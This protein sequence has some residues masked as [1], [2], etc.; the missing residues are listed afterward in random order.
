MK[1]IFLPFRYFLILVAILH[2]TA[3]S[4]QQY[5]DEKP[6]VP[7]QG[8]W[9]KTDDA[10]R[11]IRPVDPFIQSCV[12]QVSADSI[13][14][15][16]QHL[17][18]FGTRFMLVE[19]R[20]EV[21]TW[22]L[23]RFLSFGYTDV[24]LDSFYNILNWNN[25]YIDSTWQYN[26]VCTMQGSSAPDEEYIVGGHY[27]SFCAPD[28]FVAAPGANDNA[29]AVAATF[30]IAR[31][32]K[33]M[34]Y[35]PEATLKFILFGAEELGLWGSRYDAQ[36]ARETG[37]DIRYMLNMDMISN[38]PDSVKEVKIYRYI[39]SE[40]AANV[41]ADAFSRYT[42]LNI[43]IPNNQAA[44]GSDSFS[45]WMWGWPT[46]Y[47]EEMNFSPNWHLLTDSVKNCNTVYCAEI[48]RGA[49]ATLMEQ[50]KFPYPQGFTAASSKEPIKLSWKTTANSNVAGFNLYRSEVQGLE[51]LKINDAPL[52]GPDY[53][54]NSAVGGK[55]Y[56][57]FLKTVNKDM[58]ESM[59]SNVVNAARFAFTDTLLVVATLKGH[60]S[61]PDSIKNYYTAMLDTIPFVWHDM[62]LD[63]PLT[64]GKMAR[65]RNILWLINGIDF[66]FPNDTI[67]QN[68]ISF[69]G[70]GGNMM[71]CGFTPSR[72]MAH[73]SAY[74]ASFD[75]SFF[76]NHFFKID[77][78]DR[79]I[80]SFMF[81]ANPV[82]ADY[83]TLRVDSTKSMEPTFPGELYNI[84]VFAPS[85]GAAVIYKFD[86]RYPP[87]SS[88][89]KMKGRPV[90][91]EYM[92]DDFKT[93]LLSFPLYYIDTLDA[94]RLME[95]V[96]KYKFTKPVGIPETGNRSGDLALKVYPNPFSDVTNVSFTND[97][98]S[99]FTVMVY[100]MQGALSATLMNGRLDGGNHTLSIKAG[101]LPSG[102]Y[103]VV[104]K[105][106]K[107]VSTAKV[108][109]IR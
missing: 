34:N 23:K 94:R 15:T 5:F 17:Q 26:V 27:D 80:N 93:I 76:I 50:Q 102:I 87:N 59:A 29:T 91:I 28:P 31:I 67:G 44:G 53:I 57:Y 4:A 6:A 108:V 21:A 55:D 75:S 89:G 41:M 100:N 40:W 79:K 18:D 58:E 109:L 72:Y 1:K 9:Y 7:L 88:Q 38:N 105:N 99:D 82:G 77:S 65:S 16:L 48:T 47:L 69:F 20:K 74:P 33:K 61:T 63:N 42:G 95:T 97:K 43:F 84:E 103:Q 71:F 92:G 32:M 3:I 45:Y 14:A 54:D 51:Y 30:E 85:A 68:L 107:S 22:I 83:D 98:A 12:A 96:L 37:R 62:N 64:I 24:K 101:D 56:Y 19:N 106:G 13:R 2:T 39:Y 46:A 81:R 86:S 60:K 104:V 10:T 66:D 8:T 52:P 49:F 78:V 90:G 70:N 11:D 25:I 35:K 36:R 73:N